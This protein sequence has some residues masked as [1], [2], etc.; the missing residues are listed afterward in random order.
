MDSVLEGG[1]H[2]ERELAAEPIAAPAAGA[3]V[4]HLV[5]LSS[6]VWYAWV[7]GLF[8]HNFWGNPGAGG[9]MQV[10]VVTSLPLPATQVNNNVLTTDTPSP[11][12]AAPS[13]KQ[14]QHEDETAIPLPGKQPKQKPQTTPKTQMHQPTPRQNATP[15]GEQQGSFMPHQMQPGSAGPTTVGDNGFN[16]PWYVDQINRKMAQTW[17]KGEVDPR[18]PK[19][20]RVYLV[21]TIHRDGTVSGLQLDRSSGSSTLDTSCERGVQRVDTFGPLPPAYNQS[22]LKVSYFCE[23]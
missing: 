14:Q 3:L 7:L 21:F 8:H 15:Y 20:S 11:A 10:T 18:T 5:L 2:M 12:P 4:L 9:Q 19:G 13:P 17:N 6:I 23:Y 16:Y 22:T 1:A